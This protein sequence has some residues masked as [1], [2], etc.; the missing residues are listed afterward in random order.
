MPSKYKQFHKGIDSLQEEGAVQ[1]LWLTES[2]TR[3]PLLAAVG[4]LQ[5]DVIQ[6]RLQSEYGVS[7]Q[8]RHVTFKSALWIN[9]DWAA[10]KT[11]SGEQR[12]MVATDKFDEPL[13][14]FRDAWELQRFQKNNPHIE[15]LSVSP[16]TGSAKA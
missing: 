4:A 12:L 11:V 10:L 9:G 16:R 3:Y 1:V 7:T 15:L 8:L 2:E 13:L 5:F 6:F 14:L